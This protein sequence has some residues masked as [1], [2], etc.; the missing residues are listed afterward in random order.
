MAADQRA[1]HGIDPHRTPVNMRSLVI[2][3]LL[4]TAAAHAKLDGNGWRQYTSENFTLLSDIDPTLARTRLMDLELFHAV[5]LRITNAKSPANKLPTKIIVFDSTADFR[6]VVNR[7]NVGGIFMPTLRGNRMVMPK[8][9]ARLPGN[10]VLYHEY[11]HFLLRDGTYTYPK[12]YDEGLADMLGQTYVE[13]G[14]VIIGASSR[15]RVERL[16]AGDVYVSLEKIVTRD[17]IWKWNPYLNSY[18]YSMSWAAVNYIYT[19]R[20]HGKTDYGAQVPAYLKRVNA[21]APRVGAFT[22]EFGVTPMEPQR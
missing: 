1:D 8:K 11:V 18:F 14:R 21:G 10:Q 17:D 5:V 12:W 7:A 2:V 6:K 3:L 15:A 16:N 19:G 22:Q 9:V 13:N 4:F 20:L